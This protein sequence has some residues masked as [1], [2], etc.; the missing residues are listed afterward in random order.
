MK[1]LDRARGWSISRYSYDYYI[2]CTNNFEI[3]EIPIGSGQLQEKY[4]I[5]KLSSQSLAN[6]YK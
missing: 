3:I 2:C 5:V 6:L 1:V 4:E